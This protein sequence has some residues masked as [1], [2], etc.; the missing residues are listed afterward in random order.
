MSIRSISLAALWLVLATAFCTGQSRPAGKRLRFPEIE[1]RYDAVVLVS[2]V[3]SGALLGGVHTDRAMLPGYQPASLFKLAIAVAALNSGRITPAFRYRC[4][5]IDTIGGVVY[6]CWDHRGHGVIGFRD[7]IAHSCNLYFRQIARRLS[8]SEI[9]ASAR[10]LGMIGQG[11]RDGEIRLN[12]SNLLGEAFIVAP[13]QMLNTALTLASRGGRTPG[14][15]RLFDDLYRPLYD[16]LK[17]CV[18]DGTA[19]GARSSRTVIAGKTGT[20]D[21]PGISGQTVGWFIGFAPAE[22]PRYAVC[23]MLKRG[24]GSDAAAIARKVL[25]KLL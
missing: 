14:G 3:G 6:R 13:M 9:L 16:G 2:D 19:S 17:N 12:D 15:L 10:L 20:A 21:L 7:A 25:E 4:R 5:G 18:N 8:R 23:V 1:A 22:S 11:E 24:R